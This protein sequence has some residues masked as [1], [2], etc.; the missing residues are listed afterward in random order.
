MPG[1]LSVM[2]GPYRPFTVSVH[3]RSAPIIPDIRRNRTFSTSA[4]SRSVKQGFDV[5][6]HATTSVCGA[7]RQVA[8]ARMHRPMV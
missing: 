3:R 1:G 8:G 7:R 5:P 6:E 2:I 4:G